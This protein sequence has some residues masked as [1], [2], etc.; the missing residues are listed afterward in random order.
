MPT[1]YRKENKMFIHL[2]LNEADLTEAIDEWLTKRGYAV[3]AVTFTIDN[4]DRPGDG[5]TVTATTSV[6]QLDDKVSFSHHP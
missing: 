4:G 1:L 3:K 2:T 6:D 5:K